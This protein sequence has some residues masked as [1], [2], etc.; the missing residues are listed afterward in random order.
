[1]RFV[2]ESRCGVGG[3]FGVG[4]LNE[5]RYF[6]LGYFWKLPSAMFHTNN[7]FGA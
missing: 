3:S 7:G 2:S 5:Q 4:E 6:I 1:M